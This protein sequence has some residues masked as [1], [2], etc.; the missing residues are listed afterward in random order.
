[1]HIIRPGY[2]RGSLCRGSQWKRAE[3]GCTVTPAYRGYRRQFHQPRNAINAAETTDATFHKS[4]STPAQAR[5]AEAPAEGRPLLLG[6]GQPECH[7]HAVDSVHRIFFAREQVPGL[8]PEVRA[9]R[10]NVRLAKPAVRRARGGS[11]AWNCFHPSAARGLV[12]DDDR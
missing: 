3:A 7:R 2:R 10:I 4:L 5:C 11:T 6:R 1:H 9:Q 12:A 8:L